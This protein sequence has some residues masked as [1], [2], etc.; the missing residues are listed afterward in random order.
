MN[1]DSTQNLRA[2]LSTSALDLWL[3][4]AFQINQGRDTLIE[5]KKKQN[6]LNVCF[7]GFIGECFTHMIFRSHNSTVM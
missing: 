2:S 7:V 6:L 3:R 5:E 4:T 1:L